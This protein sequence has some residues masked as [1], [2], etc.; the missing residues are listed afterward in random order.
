MDA[1]LKSRH[2]NDLAKVAA[3]AFL[4]ALLL[5]GGAAAGPVSA[6]PQPARAAGLVTPEPVAREIQRPTD[7]T[8]VE[9]WLAYMTAHELTALPYAARVV[10]RAGNAAAERQDYETAVRLWRGAEEL[11]AEFLA[12]RLTLTSHFLG[13]DPAQGLI[14]VARL[15]GL[16]RTS[17]RF[18][19]FLSTYAFFYVSSALFLATLVVALLLCWRH[20]HRLQHVYS[21][22]MRKHLDL[23]RA[24]W[25]AWVACV[26]P[27]AFGFGLAVPAVFTLGLLWNYLKKGERVVFG[28]LVALLVAV[29]AGLKTFDDLSTP[30]RMSEP[31]FYST[32]GLA[33]EPYSDA[34]MAE[35]EQ[36]S[37]AQP[38]NP[39]LAYSLGWMA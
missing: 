37:A 6:A 14:E 16:A 9:G 36:L 34:R 17:F 13:R 31:P 19:H 23:P 35:L 20:R 33:Q 4:L 24:P 3:R 8:D 2:R 1:A 22:L 28:A 18:Q 21:E 38:E 39:F 27:F 12:P 29:P 5:V 10:H 26:L 32:V 25:W 30:A 15:L 11:D 7:P